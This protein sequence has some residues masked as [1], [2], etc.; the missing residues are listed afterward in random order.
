VDKLKE[1]GVTGQVVDGV[2]PRGKADV[3]GAMIGIADFNWAASGST[4]LPGAIC[5]HLTS[6]G[7]VMWANGSQTPISAFVRAGASGTSGTVTEPFAIQEKFPSPFIH[8]YYAAGCPLAEAYYQS[9]SGPYQLLILGDPLCR[10]WGRV[11][12]L[13]L[14]IEAGA[15]LKGVVKLKPVNHTGTFPAVQ[16]GLLVDGEWQKSILPDQETTLDTADLADGYHERRLVAVASDAIASQGQLIVPVTVENGGPRLVVTPLRS[17]KV[18]LTGAVVIEAAIKGAKRLL[19]MHNGREVATAAG[20]TASLRV[21]A[22]IFGA[23]PVRVQVVGV[24]GEGAEERRV[25][26]EPLRLEIGLPK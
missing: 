16:F 20:E 17:T 26:S 10:P 2:L 23:G 4:I 11:P 9:V 7:G 14:G 18:D 1:L 25:G 21:E 12:S 15:T 8:A 6:T 5:E 3:A 13:T 22:A 24:I 19:L